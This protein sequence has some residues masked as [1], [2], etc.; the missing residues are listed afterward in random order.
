MYFATNDEISLLYDPNSWPLS[1]EESHPIRFL[2]DD[3]F[4]NRKDYPDFVTRISPSI[5][6]Y[7]A[8]ENPPVFYLKITKIFIKTCLT[9]YSTVQLFHIFW[10]TMSTTMS[11]IDF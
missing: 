3:K 10:L 11:P 5:L 1:G 8:T 7:N 9:K 2:Y 4:R 6:W